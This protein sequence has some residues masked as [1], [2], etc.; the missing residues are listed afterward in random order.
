MNPVVRSLDNQAK[1]FVALFEM[2]GSKD[3]TLAD[4]AYGTYVELSR[5]LPDGAMKRDVN[6]AA[7]AFKERRDAACKVPEAP[8]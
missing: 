3:C 1:V 4:N 7:L 6:K 2:S 5:M 8:K